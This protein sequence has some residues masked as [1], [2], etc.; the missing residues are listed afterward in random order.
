MKKHS[1]SPLTE[2]SCPPYFEPD[3]PLGIF[4]EH[5]LSDK[6]LS[7]ESDTESVAQPKF[8]VRKRTAPL[9]TSQVNN[10][11]DSDEE[12]NSTINNQDRPTTRRGR[13]IKV[14][15]RYQS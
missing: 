13:A 11:D 4:N 15:T 6:E 14:P 10:T 7:S 8:N 5:S 9:K 1:P 2:K 12:D 3:P